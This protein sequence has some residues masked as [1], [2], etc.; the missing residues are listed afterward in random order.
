MGINQ[1][2]MGNQHRTT[3]PTIF[4]F[5][6]IRADLVSTLPFSSNQFSRIACPNLDG[7]LF[8]LSGF[9]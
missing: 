1:Q 4:G 5:F 6:A 9:T 2:A 8:C 3:I 7:K